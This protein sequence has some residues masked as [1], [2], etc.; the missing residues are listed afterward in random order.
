MM[1]HKMSIKIQQSVTAIVLTSIL[2]LIIIEFNSCTWPFKVNITGKIH[3]FAQLNPAGLRLTFESIYGGIN[4]SDKPDSEVVHGDG[5]FFVS[6]TFH[7]VLPQ[8][9][10]LWQSNKI[11]A[12]LIIKQE[13]DS[14]FFFDPI[15]HTSQHFK[16]SRPPVL[17]YQ[18]P[19]D[20]TD[21][22]LDPVS[23]SASLR[24][25]NIDIKG[26]M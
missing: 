13:R 10:S 25:L 24:I 7:D 23:D 2:V 11:I 19:T 20:I 9:L 18:Q 8:T 22:V 5:S 1:L 12:R 16:Y 17:G 3:N 4:N 26:T 15:A 6:S 14:I 21:L